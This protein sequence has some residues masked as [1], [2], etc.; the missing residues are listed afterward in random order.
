MVSPARA[1][2]EVARLVRSF[3]VSERWAVKTLGVSRSVIRY[4]KPPEHIEQESALTAA[5]ITAAHG[6]RSESPRSP[7]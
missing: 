2:E 3:P 7:E 5:I 4:A 1:R 6:S